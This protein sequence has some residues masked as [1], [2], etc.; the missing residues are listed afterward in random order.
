MKRTK[1]ASIDEISR[2]ILQE[3]QAEEQIKIAEHQILRG[4]T[5]PSVDSEFGQNLTKLANICR[6][7]SETPTVSYEDLR[8]F[9]ERVTR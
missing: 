2:Q 1:T 3:I 9:V 8:Q 7:L 4:V 6:E 5:H